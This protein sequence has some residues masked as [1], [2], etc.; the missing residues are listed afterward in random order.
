MVANSSIVSGMTELPQKIG[1]YTIDVEIGRGAMGVV[2]RAQDNKLGRTVA[3]KLLHEMVLS[4]QEGRSRFE[5]EARALAALNHVNIA[6]IHAFE[7]EADRQFLVLEY[8]D[9]ETLAGRLARGPLTVAETLR[10]GTQIAAGLAAAHEVGIIHRDLKP[11][12]IK[13]TPDGQVK[14]LDFGLARVDLPT[15]QIDTTEQTQALPAGHLNT[16][17]GTLLGTV[18][19]MSPEQARGKTVD[20]RS[21]I[22]SFAVILWECL[23]GNN[24]FAGSTTSDTLA[25][26]LT[27]DIDLTALPPDT[28]TLVSHLLRRCLQRDRQSRWRDAGDLRL[29]LEDCRTGTEDQPT[30]ELKPANITNKTFLV[31]DNICRTLDKDGFDPGLLGWRMQ[32]ADNERASDTLQVW[33]PSFGEDHSMG[34]WRDLLAAAPYRTIVATPVGLEPDMPYRPHISMANQLVLLRHLVSA[35]A[36]QLQ[37]ARVVV[38]GFS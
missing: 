30:A 10:V 3:L 32:Y 33:I 7:E 29:L 34:A 2:C 1:S 9:G 15:P 38:A 8:V 28:P 5:R 20:R 37:P 6:A 4:D 35:V 21:D 25:A 12:N 14:V 11:A 26:I 31:D 23:T 24:P 27:S 36:V 18:P 13:I 19:Y 22:W 16:T 17:A